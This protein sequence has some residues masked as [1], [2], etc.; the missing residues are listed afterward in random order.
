MRKKVEQTVEQGRCA[1]ETE[2]PQLSAKRLFTLW[3]SSGDFS[4]F[5][6]YLYD[7]QCIIPHILVTSAGLKPATLRTGI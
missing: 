4:L 5:R 2:C 6:I 3:R 1:V 7:F